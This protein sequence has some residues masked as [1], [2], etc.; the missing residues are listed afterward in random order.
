MKASFFKLIAVK[1]VI[2]IRYQLP[3]VLEWDG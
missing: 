2:I 3:I 1:V